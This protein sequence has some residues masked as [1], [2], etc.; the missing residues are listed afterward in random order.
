MAAYGCSAQPEGDGKPALSCGKPS[1]PDSNFIIERLHGGGDTTISCGPN[2][3]ELPGPH[4]VQFRIYEIVKPGGNLPG[5][6]GGGGEGEGEG[7]GEG[8]QSNTEEVRVPRAGI[9]FYPFL[10]SH[11][12]GSAA[13]TAS[14][15]QTDPSK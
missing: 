5:A 4:L 2:A 13:R 11:F 12:N 8:I 15:F 1:F 9:A 6:G 10:G 14:E 7:G 3:G